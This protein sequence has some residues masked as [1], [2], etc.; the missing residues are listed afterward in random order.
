MEM[1]LDW[2]SQQ[3]TKTGDNR[4]Y[5][6][7]GIRPDGVLCLVLDGSTS[8]PKSGELAGQIARD[9]IDWYVA[10]AE[11]VTAETLSAQLRQVHGG[12]SKRFPRGTAS[13][14]IVCL[15]GTGPALVLH[16]GDCLLGR[17]VGKG[18]LMWLI[19]PHTLANVIDD[20]PVAEIAKSHVR[21]RLTRSFR[22]R[23]FMQPDVT[24]IKVEQ[25]SS[26]VAATDGFW[27]ELN[28]EEQ[29]ML[30][31]GQISPM[32]VEADDRSV[33]TIRLLDNGQGVKFH[34]NEDSL[35]NVYIGR[36][37]VRSEP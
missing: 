31:R 37:P 12:L 2:R 27:A 23:E 21:H 11:D 24:E 17:Q 26:L 22:T 5:G 35:E 18:P 25:G 29:A 16:A 34:L 6:G 10:T 14:V 20:I 8:G 13:Y 15:A 7:V 32:I 3:G 1:Q 4:D 9:V 28:S 30:M 33:L 19:R 36:P